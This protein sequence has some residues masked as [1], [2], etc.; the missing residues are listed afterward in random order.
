MGSPTDISLTQPTICVDHDCDVN[1]SEQWHS[2]IRTQ[3]LPWASAWKPCPGRNE[4]S[5]P[6]RPFKSS[7]WVSHRGPTSHL[8]L[9]GEFQSWRH[10]E[11]L[12]NKVK[13]VLLPSKPRDAHPHCCLPVGVTRSSPWWQPSTHS[14]SST[15]PSQELH[16]CKAPKGPLGSVLSWAWLPL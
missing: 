13:I 16:T 14:Q 6:T 8:I 4:L 12:L 5:S 3:T 15:F 11:D 7:S 1:L 2:L 9:H 10:P